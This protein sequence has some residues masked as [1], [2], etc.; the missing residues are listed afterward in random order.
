[1]RQALR[2]LETVCD[3]GKQIHPVYQSGGRCEDCQALEW[4]R[5]HVP[6]CHTFGERSNGESHENL[7]SIEKA[8]YTND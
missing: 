7:T 3:C 2:L 8:V 4:Q 1:M 5:H 6:G